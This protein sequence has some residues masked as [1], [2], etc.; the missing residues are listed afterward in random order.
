MY[1]RELKRCNVS[2][3]Y[4]LVERIRRATIVA[5]ISTYGADR[6]A[7]RLLDILVEW[8]QRFQST[9]QIVADGNLE[10]LR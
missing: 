3:L 6:N 1:V 4:V 5:T 10:R 2:R 8:S 7:Y 9:A